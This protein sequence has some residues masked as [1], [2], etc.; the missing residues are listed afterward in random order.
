M[1][2]LLLRLL[3]L[4]ISIFS[5]FLGISQ[6]QRSF[7]KYRWVIEKSS[8]LQVDGK[9]NVCKFSCKTPDYPYLDTITVLE[10]SSANITL[11]GEIEMEVESFKCNTVMMTKGLRKAVKMSEYPKMK[12]RF[13]NLE[14]MPVLSKKNEIIKGWVEITLAGVIK[15]FEIN[16]GLLSNG[17]AILQLNGQHSFLFTDF[18]LVPPSKFGGIIRISNDF[19]VNFQLILR[20]I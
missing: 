16:Y 17:N 10:N 20:T 18:H 11:T 8:T 4:K 19:D 1:K 7:A 2:T 15:Q 3:F 14:S 12:I 9:S 5:F 6:S 13:I